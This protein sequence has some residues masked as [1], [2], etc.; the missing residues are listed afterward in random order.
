MYA[1]SL[2]EVP[3]P[4]PWVLRP[5]LLLFVLLT[6]GGCGAGWRRPELI[7]PGSLPARQQVQ[8]WAGGRVLRLHGVIVGADTVSGIPFTRSLDCDSCRVGIGQA[9]VD[10]MR[11][12]DPVGGFWKTAALGVAVTLVAC[13]ASAGATVGVH[14]Q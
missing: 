1:V 12:G 2:R 14:E 8:I 5:A 11:I 3:L 9:E 6:I 4:A 13:V 10:S 7:V